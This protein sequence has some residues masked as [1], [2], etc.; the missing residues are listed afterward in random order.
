MPLMKHKKLKT[1]VIYYVFA[2]ILL[3][4]LAFAGYQALKIYLP[5]S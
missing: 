1:P 3:L 4:I 2:G 5:Q